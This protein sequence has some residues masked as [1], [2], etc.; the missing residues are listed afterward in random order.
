MAAQAASKAVMALF[1]PIG[2][3]I[4]ENL[5]ALQAPSPSQATASLVLTLLT[6]YSHSA[7]L[8]QAHRTDLWP[9]TQ[10]MMSM[11]TKKPT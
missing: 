10:G 8:P 5:L 2:C 9:I 7:E 6:E 4:N 11:K 3:W 1:S